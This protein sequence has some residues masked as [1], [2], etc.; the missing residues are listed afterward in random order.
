MKKKLLFVISQLYKGG[1][2]TSLVNL[3]NR[4]DKTK[5]DVDLLVLNQ[6]PVENGVSLIGRLNKDVRVCDAYAEYQ[7]L[8]LLSRVHG[9]LVYTTEQKSAY[10]LPALDFVRNKEYDWA[11]FV[12]EWCLPSFVAYEVNAKIKAAWI[13]SDISVAEYFDEHGYFYFLDH[14]DYLIFVSKNSMES[15]IDR[16]PFIKEKAVCIYNINNAEYIFSRANEEAEEFPDSTLPVVLT[17]ANIRPE[18]NHLRQVNVMIELKR[19]G[20]EFLW[21]NIGSKANSVLTN[22]VETLCKKEGLENNF[23]LLGAKENPYAYISRADAVTVLSDHESWSMVITEAKILG[24]PVIATKTSGA[25]EQIEHGTTGM[26]ADFDVMD[27]A[28]KMEQFLKNSELRKSIKDNIKNFDNTEEI[29]AEFEKLIENGI[30]RKEYIKQQEDTILY[31]I[32]DINYPG[33]AHIATKQQIANLVQQGKCVSVFSCSVPNAAI[34]RELDG[35]NFLSYKDFPRDVLL[36]KTIGDCLT[37]KFVSFGDKVKKVKELW[38]IKV[39][40]NTVFYDEYVL[41][42]LSKLISQFDI[43]CVMS[44]SSQFR[45]AAS[46]SNCKRK[47]QWVHTDYCEWRNLSDWT[48]QLTANDKEL[49]KEFDAIVLLTETIKEKFV[50]L[51]PELESKVV[52]NQNLMPIAEIKK[53]AMALVDD[54][55]KKKITLVSFEEIK[56]SYDWETVLLALSETKA[57]GVNFCWKIFGTGNYVWKVEKLAS[58]LNLLGNVEIHNTEYDFI[59]EVKKADILACFFEREDIAKYIY[60]SLMLDTPVLCREMENVS[61]RILA[62]EHGWIMRREK[63]AFAEALDNILKDGGEYQKVK[64]SVR[65]YKLR[66][67]KIKFVTVARIDR[68]KNYPRL[69]R[70]LARLKRIGFEFQW[71]IIGSG[72]DEATVYNMI[73][74]FGLSEDITVCGQI[75]NPFAE[76]KKSDVFVLLSEYEG[77]PNTIYEAL[78]LGMPVLATD[79]GG[80]STQIEDGINGWLVQNNESEITCKLEWLLLNEEVVKTVKETN[81]NYAYN[82]QK[83]QAINNELFLL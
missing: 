42:E 13:H 64:Y 41:P 58:E 15:S 28:D 9:K 22:K 21:V 24:T 73:N 34:R 48:K 12:G 54:E 59:D 51:Y 80:I 7:N 62:P 20:I 38:E 75:N 52:V 27:I 23:L 71:T 11:F 53:K 2:E 43:V 8:S 30:N 33:G 74:E 1:A 61:D 66:N 46:L 60:E 29:L 6:C 70:V 40:K 32:D 39:E 81:S 67:K 57:K 68:Y 19:R 5:F 83:I 69:L 4:L 82:N 50:Q 47:I 36:N 78:I 49:Y 77:I 79:V 63:K 55:K 3:L 25:L 65:G 14:M 35:V 76:M 45:K 31:I 72:E 37:N 44:E 26:L 18:K 56:N 17:C 16:Y 10:F